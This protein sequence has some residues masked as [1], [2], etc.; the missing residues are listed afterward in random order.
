[1][2]KLVPRNVPNQ[3]PSSAKISSQAG[4]PLVLLQQEQEPERENQFPLF[5]FERERKKKCKP[6]L[7]N[8]KTFLWS[9]F[10]NMF[11]SISR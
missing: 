2:Q 7:I 3:C 1:M 6:L 4:F 11:I 10:Q 8:N 5:W 9:L